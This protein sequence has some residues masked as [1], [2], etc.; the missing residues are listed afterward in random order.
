M[1]SAAT[2]Q[3]SGLV[4]VRDLREDASAVIAEVE[5][6]RWFVVSKRGNPVGV[7]LPST[8]A[9][10]LLMQHAAEIL[11]LQLAKHQGSE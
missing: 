10:R 3:P 7:L 11:A 8:M 4:G 1:P 2:S 6:G 5:K 9:Q